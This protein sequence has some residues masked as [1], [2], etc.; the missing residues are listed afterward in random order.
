[1][2][3]R[4][5]HNI[6]QGGFWRYLH[7]EEGRRMENAITFYILEPRAPGAKGMYGKHCKGKGCWSN[8]SFLIIYLY[9]CLFVSLWSLKKLLGSAHCNFM[10]LYVLRAQ[11]EA[12]QGFN[13]GLR[14][15]PASDTLPARFPRGL[16]HRWA[17]TV[18]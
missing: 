2:K 17:G 14:A 1:M 12:L 10:Y 13:I 16:A 9:L 3:Q 8:Y 7:I 18:C 6:L 4:N 5:L 11:S 15:E